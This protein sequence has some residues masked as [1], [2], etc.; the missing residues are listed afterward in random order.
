MKIWTTD[1]YAQAVCIH[2]DKMDGETK[3][4]VCDEEVDAV[5]NH[6]ASLD[7]T[8]GQAPQHLP[9]GMTPARFQYVT[10]RLLQQRSGDLFAS[11]EDVFQMEWSQYSKEDFDLLRRNESEHV[12]EDKTVKLVYDSTR[13]AAHVKENRVSVSPN[14]MRVISTES[15]AACSDRTE[16]LIGLSVSVR[17]A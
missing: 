8:T 4:E 7:L 11:L 17:A 13:Q 15:N 14:T 12:I 5:I 6:I 3:T 10:L 2:A 9:P 1:R 16:P